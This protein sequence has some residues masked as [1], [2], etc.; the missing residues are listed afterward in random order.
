MARFVG[1]QQNLH[2]GVRLGRH[3]Q[4]PA[5]ERDGDGEHGEVEGDDAEDRG[6]AALVEATVDGLDGLYEPRRTDT[7]D[8][9][10]P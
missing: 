10:R 3:H 8:G 4:R 6:G 2:V 5:G 7:A 1:G 9:E